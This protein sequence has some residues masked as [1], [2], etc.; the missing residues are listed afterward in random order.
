MEDLN[1]APSRRG[2]AAPLAGMSRRLVEAGLDPCWTEQRI[3]RYRQ[4]ADS[5]VLTARVGG[6]IAGGA[7]MEFG[8][9][10]ARLDLLVVEPRFRRRGVARALVVWLE[11]SARTAG[12]FRITLEVRA[13]NATARAFY[14]RLGYVQTDWLPGYYQDVEDALRL[15]RGLAVT[16]GDM[17]R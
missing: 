8:D 6:V 3:D 17:P 15:E 11:E 1:I 16:V 10:A 13:G 5:L 4:R 9:D 7:V 2:D 12:T 14:A